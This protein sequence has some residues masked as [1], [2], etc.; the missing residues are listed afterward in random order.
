MIPAYLPVSIPQYVSSV[1]NCSN[2][3]VVS[4]TG[5]GAQLVS[6]A[7]CYPKQVV[8]TQTITT[9]ES[10]S[11]TSITYSSQGPHPHN[12]KR[13]NML[14]HLKTIDLMWQYIKD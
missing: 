14:I 9:G 2:Q 3:A 4:Q 6:L 13:N 7:P 1:E 8:A 11:D 5:V 12:V 10:Q